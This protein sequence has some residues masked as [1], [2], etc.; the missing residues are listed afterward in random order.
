MSLRTDM[1]DKR[2]VQEYRELVRTAVCKV[3]TGVSVCL[4]EI[5]A[6]PKGVSDEARR[7][8]LAVETPSLTVCSRAAPISFHRPVSRPNRA[9]RGFCPQQ[10]ASSVCLKADSIREAVHCRPASEF[11][12]K[13]RRA[14]SDQRILPDRLMASFLSRTTGWLDSSPQRSVNRGFQGRHPTF[15][16]AWRREALRRH[17]RRIE[18]LAQTWNQVYS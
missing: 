8:I 11:Q 14:S 9:A 16:R 1:A 5:P 10:R 15:Q 3:R 18:R 6:A 7:W 4:Q 12:Q 17:R 2:R 13:G